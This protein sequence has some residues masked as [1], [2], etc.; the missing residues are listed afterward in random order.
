MRLQSDY[1]KIS[2]QENNQKIAD[3]KAKK[4]FFSFRQKSDKTSL[5]MASKITIFNKIKHKFTYISDN[6]HLH[7]LSN[8]SN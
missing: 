7:F 5:S 2:L 3:D 6:N 8:M 1:I 4:L